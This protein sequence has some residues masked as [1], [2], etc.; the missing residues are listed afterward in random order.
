MDTEEMFNLKSR[1]IYLAEAIEN[2][3]AMIEANRAMTEA[4]SRK[5]EI[6]ERRI[7]EINQILNC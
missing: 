5:L 4:L 6:N 7:G 2:T 3:K 1:T